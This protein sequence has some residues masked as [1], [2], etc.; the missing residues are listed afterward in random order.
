MILFGID[1]SSAQGNVDWT[2]IDATTS[3]GWSKVTQGSWYKNPYWAVA[4]DGMAA[5]A[6]ATGF[7][8][9]AYLFLEAGDGAAQADWFA[10][11]AGD[12]D[13]FAIAVDVEPAATSR[14]DA[15]AAQACVARLRQLYPHKPIGGYIPH[16]Y[17]GSQSTTFVDWLWASDY[18]TAAQASPA[19]LYLHVT[20]A[21]WSAYGGQAPDLLQFTDK[22]IVAGA[23]GPV[24]CSAFR[25]TLAEL[26]AV[27]LSAPY[28]PP[29]ASGKEPAMFYLPEHPAS[30]IALPAGARRVRF[31][32]AADTAVRV[33]WL[34]VPASSVDLTLGY[35]QGAQ[36]APVPSGCMAAVVHRTAPAD[37]TMPLIAVEILT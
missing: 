19:T 29:V 28:P 16:W 31:V 25:G 34:A 35:G 37:G 2:A 33:D 26:R 3:F 7:V 11:A 8:G 30:P 27:L 4:K 5:R 17:W 10:K 9:G 20:D 18:V 36:G 32:S 15:A 6:K 21:M 24:D 12:L 22:A 23:P 1:V 13:G 14:P